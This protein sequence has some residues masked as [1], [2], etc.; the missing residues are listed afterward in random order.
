MIPLAHYIT[1]HELVFNQKIGPLEEFWKKNTKAKHLLNLLLK[2]TNLKTKF[3]FYGDSRHAMTIVE[4]FIHD[5]NTDGDVELFKYLVEAERKQGDVCVEDLL[6]RCSWYFCV[7]IL[8]GKLH[9]FYI[10]MNYIYLT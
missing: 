4:L 10:Q 1:T 3:V 5:R 8:K 9:I 7:D 6:W 2:N